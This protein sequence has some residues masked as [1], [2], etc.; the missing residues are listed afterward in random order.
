MARRGELQGFTGVDDPYEPPL[1]PEMKLDTVLYSAE[2][3]AHRILDHLIR[4]GYV[5][6][7]EISVNGE[8]E[9]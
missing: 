3:N 7:E 8:K 4:R 1:H 5:R 9:S 6:H 2:E